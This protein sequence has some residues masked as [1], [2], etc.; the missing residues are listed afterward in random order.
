MKWQPFTTMCYVDDVLTSPQTLL[1][2]KAGFL[3]CI[4]SLCKKI[5]VTVCIQNILAVNFN[6]HVFEMLFIFFFLPGDHGSASLSVAFLSEV[7]VF[8][9]MEDPFHTD[10]C[11]P[12]TN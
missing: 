11:L 12:V 1:F 10:G 2:R 9:Q 7:C 6:Q 4:L 3:Y 8:G 5:E